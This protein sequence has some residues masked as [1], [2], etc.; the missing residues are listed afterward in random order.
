VFFI[1]HGGNKIGKISSDGMMTEF[2][3]PTGPLATSVFL[4]VTENGK[5]IWF[6]EWAS[7]KI[8]YLDNTLQ[9]PLTI[10]VTKNQSASMDSDMAPLTLKT[11]G[12][13]PLNLSL[14]LDKNSSSL[15]I[16]NDTKL[17]LVGMT[18]SGLQGVE[19]TL[20]A[21][22]V[23]LM[24]TPDR[25]VGIGLRV[26]TESAIAGNYTFMIRASLLENDG[27]VI[28]L[29]SPQLVKLDVPTKPAEINKI[30]NFRQFSSKNDV[31]SNSSAF[32]SDLIRIG[33]IAVII[34]LVGYLIYHKIK[35]R[36]KFNEH[37]S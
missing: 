30:E 13:F 14:S 31:S 5:Q 35:R 23:N 19:Y 33:A 37:K 20:E 34:I 25:H 36:S 3:I 17:S 24:E 29:L 22:S 21:Q 26:E 27:L 1:E 7:N 9:V 12:S 11:G 8:A 6:T 18:D 28:S 10:S 32:F 4:T 15:A 2:D 16:A